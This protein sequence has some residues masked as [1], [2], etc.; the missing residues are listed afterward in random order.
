MKKEHLQKRGWTPDEIKEAE[1][2]L[3]K[4]KNHDIHFSKIVFWSALFVVVLGNLALSLIL[5]P[6]L[7]IFKPWVL[8]T[9]VII[10][11]LMMGSIYSF[12]VTDIGHLER[13]HHVFAAI[14]VP[15]IAIINLVVIVITAN[16]FIRET[17]KEPQNQW[18][19]AAIF[20]VSFI[21]PFLIH[22]LRNLIKKKP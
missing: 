9:I 21:L 2:L 1:S 7:L 12:L 20:V 16:S 5:I 8:H 15:V 14:F 10:L 17:V 11:G 19:V 13:K 4:A 3:E 22:R 18:I 6:F